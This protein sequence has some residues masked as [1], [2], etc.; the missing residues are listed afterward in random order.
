MVL[1]DTLFGGGEAATVNVQVG[2][3]PS[4]VR[5]VLGADE[6]AAEYVG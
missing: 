5:R 4:C 1:R 6:Q 3:L 2:R